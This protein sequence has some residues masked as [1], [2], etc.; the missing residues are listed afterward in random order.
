M[1]LHIAQNHYAAM[2]EAV[3][4]KAVHKPVKE[5]GAA[6]FLTGLQC[7]QTLVSAAHSHSFGVSLSANQGDTQQQVC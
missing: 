2:Q 7:M 6:A 5:A 4:F 1:Q 3:K